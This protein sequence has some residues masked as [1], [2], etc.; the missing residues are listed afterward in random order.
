MWDEDD[1]I[2]IFQGGLTDDDPPFV[3]YVDGEWIGMEMISRG[4]E[5]IDDSGA[6][7]PPHDDYVY[8]K[9]GKEI[10]YYSDVY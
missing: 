7:A 2:F 3:G 5:K 9:N 10:V 1:K 4:G 8:T 6:T